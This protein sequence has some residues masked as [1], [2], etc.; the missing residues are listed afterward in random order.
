[1]TGAGGVSACAVARSAS[2]ASAKGAFGAS[3]GGAASPAEPAQDARWAAHAPRAQAREQMRAD[4]Q[5]AQTRGVDA[6][7]AA[8]GA[9]EGRVDDMKK[10][11]RERELALY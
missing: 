10:S 3:S 6:P 2:G 11:T 5:L 7:Q 1:M 8:Q 9:R 4:R